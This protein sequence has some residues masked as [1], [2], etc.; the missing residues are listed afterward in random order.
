MSHLL[1]NDQITRLSALFNKFD[2]DSSGG[3][4][5]DELFTL[6]KTAGFNVSESQIMDL[7]AELDTDGSNTIDFQ[8]FVAL[9]VR[10]SKTGDSNTSLSQKI[11]LFNDEG[12]VT[13]ET[14]KESFKETN[15]YFH[16]NELKDL[17][18]ELNI[19]GDGV[20]DI[21]DIKKF[22]LH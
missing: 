13:I 9:V 12:H 14:L 19:S 10:L 6:L 20:V 16:P 3:I 2:F 5:S 8:E 15:T 17:L 18:E 4:G 1:T 22:L 21:E 11:T 7:I